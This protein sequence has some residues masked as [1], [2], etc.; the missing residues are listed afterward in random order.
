MHEKKQPS[1]FHPRNSKLDRKQFRENYEKNQS[2]KCSVC[3][4]KL[5]IMESMEHD[6]AVIHEG[7]KPIECSTC[8]AR[9]SQ[10][11]E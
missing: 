8:S 9:S 10:L 5:S 3:Q 11:E 4:I 2:R 7:E 1:N 6:V